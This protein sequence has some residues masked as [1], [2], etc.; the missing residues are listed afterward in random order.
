MPSWTSDIFLAAVT[1]LFIGLFVNPCI[2]AGKPRIEAKN[3]RKRLAHEARAEFSKRVLTILSAC[4]RL[5]S[6]EV[7]AREPIPHATPPGYVSAP[8]PFPAGLA[9]DGGG[10]KDFSYPHSRW[11]E[12]LSAFVITSRCAHL[13]KARG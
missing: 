3:N 13:V 8:V 10:N 9:S 2:E 7:P 11:S 5:Q 6:S 12:V 4:G 1:T